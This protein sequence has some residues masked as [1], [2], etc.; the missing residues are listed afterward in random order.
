[1]LPVDPSTAPVRA[2]KMRVAVFI[3][4]DI[5]YRHFIRSRAFDDLAASHDVM[6][7]FPSGDAA[8][9]RMTIAVDPDDVS[10][11]IEY[12]EIDAARLYQW[13]RL[14]QVSQLV[15]R[16][17]LAWKRLRIISRRFL[18]P[19]A[20]KLFTVLA[21]PGIFEIF[22][23][24]SLRTIKAMP[25]P[26]AD[27]MRRTSPDIL[28]HPTVLDGLF[29]NDVVL[30]AA[31]FGIPSILIMNSWDNPSTKRAVVGRPDRLLVWGQQTKNH[32][33]TFMGME[34]DKV[35]SFGAAQFD[36]YRRPARIDR[37]EFCR[38]HD[39]DSA[40]PILLY[41]GSSK[42]SDEFQHL[43]MI[44]D[45]IHNGVLPD[46]AV[47]YRPHP[48][49]NG[50]FNGERIIGHAWRHIHIEE[51][52]RGYLERVAAGQKG[53][54]LP[55]YGDTHDLLSAIDVLV[56]PLST[57]ILEAMLHGKPVLCFLPDAQVDSSLDLQASLVHFEDMYSNPEVLVA[58]GDDALIGQLKILAGRMSEPAVGQRMRAAAHHFVEDFDQPYDTR[59]TAFVARTAPVE[60]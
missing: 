11:E 34:P 5:I 57:I 55:D 8:A 58:T 22:R 52:M 21:L 53:I 38:L 41:A 3:E 10:G 33:I 29:I 4:H 49:G 56:S 24:H 36:L 60:I 59:L 6:F 12:V 50:G 27:L 18:G 28:V 16:P 15:W 40:K 2:R 19:R 1:M 23:W 14:F 51:S 45:A 26:M 20:S 30:H 35:V 32:A 43:R 44:E 46:I 31:E 42:G 25:S 7:V 39:I 47:V 54:S 37:A 48:W 17:G 13:R 9:K